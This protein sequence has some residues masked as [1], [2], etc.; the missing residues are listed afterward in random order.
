MGAASCIARRYNL[1]VN[2]LIHWLFWFLH[3]LF[4]NVTIGLCSTSPFF[5]WLW[6]SVMISFCGRDVSYIF[7][8]G[9]VG[10]YAT[11]F[12]DYCDVWELCLEECLS[13]KDGSI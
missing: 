4:C 10:I 6:F 8:L 9:K 3:P 1:T 13:S 2:S 12:E 5:D 11:L 7:S